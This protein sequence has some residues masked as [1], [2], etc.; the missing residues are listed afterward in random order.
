MKKTSVR[1]GVDNSWDIW[2]QSA[3]TVQLQRV[4]QV[5]PTTAVSH[6][7]GKQR[8]VATKRNS[9]RIRTLG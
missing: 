1:V 3:Y 2:R 9:R 4:V 8:H 7:C 5:G 6:L